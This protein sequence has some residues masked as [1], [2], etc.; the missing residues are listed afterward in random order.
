[1]SKTCAL[2]TFVAAGVLLAFAPSGLSQ[3][4]P[5]GQSCDGD[6]DGQLPACQNVWQPYVSAVFLGRV[7]EI[8]TE[9]VPIT[10]DGERKL[11]EK[12][13]VTFTV[14]E[15]FRGV[16]NK[17][18]NTIS[19]GDLCGFPFSKG[20]KYLVY[21]RQLPS[22]ELYVSTCYGTNFAEYATDD[23]K[24]LR[25]LPNA[26]PGGTIYGTAFRFAEPLKAEF[27]LRR[28]LPET[29]REIQVTGTTRSY[30]ANVDERGNF[31]VTGL[32]PGRYSVLFKTEGEVYTSPPVKSTTVE[33]ADKG[34]ARFN[35]WVDPYALATT[36][37]RCPLP[38]GFPVVRVDRENKRLFLQS[39][40]KSVSVA[41]QVKIASYLKKLDRAINDCE[42]SWKAGWSVSFFT[43]P[44]LAGYK[45][46][47]ALSEAVEN[48]DWGRAYIAEYDRST[49][50]LTIFPLDSQKRQTR[51][52]NVGR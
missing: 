31:S 29:G 12:Q 51:Q 32:P 4:Q 8:R 20:Q 40:E 25:G 26:P 49:Q 28:S 44:K 35:F 47:T 10:L 34:C 43:D 17:V 38:P 46:D 2:L 3:M 33:V 36:T 1:M 45:T 48:G 19:G 50:V 24:Y 11:T 42:P 13:F 14:V 39:S 52:V 30:E 41:S 16:S 6:C 37:A 22:G 5:N 9:D 15:P 27:Q 18:V 7:T 23:L 21:A